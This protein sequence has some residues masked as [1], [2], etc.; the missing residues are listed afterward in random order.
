MNIKV[1]LD[2]IQVEYLKTKGLIKLL[3]QGSPVQ[4]IVYRQVA[5]THIS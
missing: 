1:V 3:K 5:L 2:C 4:P